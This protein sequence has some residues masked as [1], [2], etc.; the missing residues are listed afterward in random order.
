MSI[1]SCYVQEQVSY[2]NT[3]HLFYI[4]LRNGN[5]WGGQMHCNEVND[6]FQRGL[7]SKKNYFLKC[8][9]LN[10][11]K[12][13]WSAARHNPFVC[14]IGIH[15]PGGKLESLCCLQPPPGCTRLGAVPL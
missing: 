3:F 12:V 7:F 11:N 6:R 1:F 8:T 2:N 4:G 10:C 14:D 9:H 13:H 15:P 5:D